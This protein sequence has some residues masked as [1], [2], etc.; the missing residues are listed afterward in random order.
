MDAFGRMKRRKIR[1]KEGRKVKKT[2]LRFQLSYSGYTGLDLCTVTG[3]SDSW[4]AFFS[5]VTPTHSVIII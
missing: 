1:R 2:A 5:S 4:Y 3:Y